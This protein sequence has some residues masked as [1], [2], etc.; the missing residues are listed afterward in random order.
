M[1]VSPVT[2]DS[3]SW[4]ADVPIYAFV[5]A[6]VDS[7]TVILNLDD[8]T[9]LTVVEGAKTSP[10]QRRVSSFGSSA[11]DGDVLAQKAYQDRQITI[12]L[13]FELGSTAEQQS[14]TL[15][16]LG[17]ILDGESWLQWQ[18][19]GKIEPVF[20]RVKF[21]DI[22]IDDS[23]ADETPDR[24]VTLNLV[25][26]P[27]GYGLPVSGSAVIDN[28]PTS[29]TNK[30]SYLFPD[31]QGDVATP[32]WLHFAQNASTWAVLA[33]TT[34]VPVGST[35]GKPI[36]ATGWASGTVAAD[37]TAISGNRT[38]GTGGST[39]SNLAFVANAVPAVPRGDYRLL[40]RC[41][42]SV[43]G[44]SVYAQTAIPAGAV[45]DGPVRIVPGTSWGWV[46]CGVFRL[47][48]YAP[49]KAELIDQT[50]VINTYLEFDV[51]LPSPGTFDMD[52]YVLIPAGLDSALDTRTALAN[53]NV[54][55][56]AD[57]LYL[58]GVSEQSYVLD[59][60]NALAAPASLAGGFPRVMP[61][62]DCHL[63][64]VR[65]IGAAG[66]DKAWDTAVD[67]TYYPLYLYDRPASS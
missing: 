48:A 59:V 57:D 50:S 62:A 1:S 64:F 51:T 23:I 63:N 43:A 3:K 18:H 67:W 7:P 52:G 56:G 2:N 60:A 65:Y 4:G 26:E 45:V 29:G 38:R 31:I 42:A 61:N 32:L 9:P 55:A 11:R 53:G 17:R 12:P 14:E 33:S 44:T 5:S 66:D 22:D 36:F 19:D 10:P 47:P 27:F 46:D 6:P 8:Q 16:A 39:P 25:A 13:R 40:L 30:M 54:S 58:D 34:C 49:R 35:E 15:Q 28:D 41:R 37:A 24:D 20:Y 21:G